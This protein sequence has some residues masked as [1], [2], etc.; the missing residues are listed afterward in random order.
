VGQDGQAHNSRGD[1][2]YNSDGSP[3]MISDL[4]RDTEELRSLNTTLHR[5]RVDN[6]VQEMWATVDGAKR[7]QV[8]TAVAMW[9]A[10]DPGR[11]GDYTLRALVGTLLA[12]EE[13]LLRAS[14]EARTKLAEAFVARA[15]FEL[16][17][18]PRDDDRFSSSRE[19]IMKA[20]LQVA[21]ERMDHVG[22]GL[23]VDAL[24]RAGGKEADK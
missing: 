17:E 10:E 16:E 23:A 20:L 3:V 1:P 18:R 12:K 24:A 6:L 19:E 4:H 9:V 22:A 11:L 2:I 5:S 7:E 14:E 8:A 15:V 13:L 21:R